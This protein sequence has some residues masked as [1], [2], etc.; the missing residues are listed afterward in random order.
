MSRPKITIFSSLE[1]CS[2]GHM[3]RPNFPR[4][5]D[6]ASERPSMP[7]EME[8]VTQ[9]VSNTEHLTLRHITIESEEAAKAIGKPKGQY[10]TLEF[11]ALWQMTPTIKESVIH[12][13]SQQIEGLARG[14]FQGKP[15]G[16]RVVLVAGLGNRHLTADAIGPLT[17]DQVSAT[18]HIKQTVPRLFRQMGCAGVCVLSPGVVAETGIDAGDVICDV[19]K[20]ISPDLVVCVDALAAR[21]VDRLATTIQLTDTGITPGSG[22]GNHRKALSKE[23]LGI[24]CIAIGTPTVVSAFTLL[25]DLLQETGLGAHFEDMIKNKGQNDFFVCPKDID[26]AVKEIGSMVAS[27]IN[28]LWG[29]EKL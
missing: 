15:K 14:V 29:V 23:T 12:T 22:V 1:A 20:A 17:T 6:L 18:Y 4:E 10:I 19:A 8:G 27:A 24:P 2:L 3:P 28:R 21:S 16:Q 11:P 26:C 9:R 5:S 25:Y 13:L 7:S